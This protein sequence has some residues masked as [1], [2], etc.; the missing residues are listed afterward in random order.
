MP[1]KRKNEALDEMDEVNQDD[2]TVEDAAVMESYEEA[3]HLSVRFFG[4]FLAKCTAK[5]EDD[6]RRLFEQFLN[7]LLIALYRPA[8]PVAELMLTVLGNLL[9]KKYRS[10]GE[11]SSRIACLDYL[12]TIAARLR[13]DRVSARQDDKT[14]LDLVLKCIVSDESGEAIEKIDNSHVRRLHEMIYVQQFGALLD[15]HG[16]Q[17]SNTT[18]STHR[19]YCYEE[20]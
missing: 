16:R 5:S 1:S 8:W 18:A 13:R 11:A 15:D 7:D 6:Y 10:K 2:I 4:G 9:V 20:R 12:G 14:R 19:L 17:T 3:Q